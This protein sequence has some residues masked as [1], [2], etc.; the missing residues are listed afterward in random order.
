MQ[1]GF[2]ELGYLTQEIPGIGG[3]IKAKAQ[4][5]QVKEIPLYPASGIGE[6]LYLYIEKCNISTMD[7]VYQL[8]RQL[9]I[10]P[11]DVGYAGR[12][13]S[14]AVS[15]Q[16]LS[17]PY[18]CEPLLNKLEIPGVSILN[19][20]KH[21][22]KLRIGHLSGNHF[23]ILVR[24]IKED[25]EKNLKDILAIL[26][27]RGVP[28]YFGDQRFGLQNNTHQIGKAM[29][30]GNPEE[31]CDALFQSN[32]PLESV[33]LQEAIALYKQ[34]KY[35]EAMMIIPSSFSTEKYVLKMLAFG[36]NKKKATERIPWKIQKFY[37][38]AYQSSLFNRTLN[39]RLEFLD[40]IENGDLAVKHPG[41]SVFL[42]EDAAIEQKRCDAWEISPSGPIFGHKMIEPQENQGEREKLI[43]QEEGIQL[44]CFHP[45]H[46]KGE[47][48]TYRFSLKDVQYER[49]Q[50][51][52]WISFILPKGCYA[53]VVLREIMKMPSHN[54]P[55]EESMEE[56]KN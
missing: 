38:C 1:A 11:N 55:E 48:R 34:G 50:E 36:H 26:Q 28:N 24:D 35:Q 23:S 14:C 22:N 52:I 54:M 2:Q 4:D 8:S 47:R 31:I 29:L 37:V 3:K 45:F 15:C 46:L 30:L 41:N 20:Q 18:T 9:H 32:A 5:F 44:D 12:K 10:S 51:G 13:D 43:L 49:V 27:K 33:A 21:S 53:T 25:A 40:R 39:S 7:L 6:H 16:Y 56:E 17:V 42:V 19:Q